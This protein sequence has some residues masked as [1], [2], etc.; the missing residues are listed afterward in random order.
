MNTRDDGMPPNPIEAV[1]GALSLQE[2]RDLLLEFVTQQ[3]MLQ[4][5]FNWLTKRR[6]A[7]YKATLGNGE[8]I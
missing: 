5:F 7:A 8:V 3:K 1:M 4:R 2:E 6:L